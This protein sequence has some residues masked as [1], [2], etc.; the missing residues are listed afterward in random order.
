M[1]WDNPECERFEGLP[2]CMHVSFPTRC[3]TKWQTRKR[4]KWR[5]FCLVHSTNRSD[6]PVRGAWSRS[7]GLDHTERASTRF[8]VASGGVLSEGYGYDGPGV[9]L[10]D[11]QTED[12]GVPSQGG[13]G[14]ALLRRMSPYLT[15]PEW[16]TT[17]SA[18]FDCA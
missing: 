11:G 15:R 12:E 18:N 9:C 7:K 13:R 10:G 6:V 4:N 8:T 17:I 3:C 1:K 14:D 16:R 2:S 5:P